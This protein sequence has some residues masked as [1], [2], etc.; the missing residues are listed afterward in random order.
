[1]LIGVTVD[2]G[3]EFVVNQRFW[4]QINTTDACGKADAVH[5]DGLDVVLSNCGL[6]GTA[7]GSASL[8][9]NDSGVPVPIS[10]RGTGSRDQ[11]PPTPD[12]GGPLPATPFDTFA[13]PAPEPLPMT[14]TAR[15]VAYDGTATTLTPTVVAGGAVSLVLGFSKPDVVLRAGQSYDV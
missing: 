2:N 3:R 15:L 4:A 8:S 10:A 11:T 1:A 12:T 13:L 5:Y 6:V 7:S 14:A 9:Y